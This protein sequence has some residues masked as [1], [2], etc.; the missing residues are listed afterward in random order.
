MNPNYAKLP[1]NWEST[2]GQHYE[3]GASDVEVRAALR[4]TVGVWDSLY[5]DAVDSSFKEVVDF[6][7]MFSKAWWQKQ[8]RENLKDRNFNANLWYMVMKNQFGWS[9]KSGGGEKDSPQLT[10]DEL[11]AQ[12]KAAADK[13]YKTHKA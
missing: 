13:F 7:R 10:E 3:E 5:N 11:N 1:K 2:I 4:M 9:D 12:F 8:A 6:G